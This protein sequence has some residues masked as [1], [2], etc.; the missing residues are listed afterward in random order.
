[1]TA[2]KVCPAANGLMVFSECALCCASENP[3]AKKCADDSAEN[4][5]KDYD[6]VN[7]RKKRRQS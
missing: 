2:K 5:S 1:M 3:A 4:M 7:T 6:W